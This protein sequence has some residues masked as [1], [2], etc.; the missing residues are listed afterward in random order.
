MYFH[1]RPW[2]AADNKYK[3]NRMKLIGDPN[4]STASTVFIFT[5]FAMQIHLK[6]NF[7][8]WMFTKIEKKCVNIGE[9]SFTPLMYGF[10]CTNFHE[11]RT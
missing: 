4:E 7:F 8:Y 11:T 6:D 9:I 1:L 5:K 3:K 2:I 10:H